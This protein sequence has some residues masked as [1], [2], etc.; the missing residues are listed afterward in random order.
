MKKL[1]LILLLV[2][3][4]VSCNKD[5]DSLKDP[6]IGSW[7]SE[8]QDIYDGKYEVSY[9][10]FSSNGVLTSSTEEIKD[11]NVIYKCKLILVQ[12]SYPHQYQKNL[13]VTQI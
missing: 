10:T 11:G 13:Q 3:L 1:L 4:V 8:P 5:D 9:N 7:K 12:L 2:P 6:I